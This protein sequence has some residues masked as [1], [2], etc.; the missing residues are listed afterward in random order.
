VECKTSSIELVEHTV[1]LSNSKT[2]QLASGKYVYY[3]T[4]GGVVQTWDTAFKEVLLP[5]I[6]LFDVNYGNK[7]LSS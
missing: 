6:F 7:S 5:I 4:F 2:E 1:S 3:M